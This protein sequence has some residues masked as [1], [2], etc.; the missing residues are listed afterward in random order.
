M[1]S[2][3]KKRKAKGSLDLGDRLFKK[4]RALD[5]LNQEIALQFCP[6]LALFGSDMTLGDDFMDEVMDSTPLPI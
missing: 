2:S 3:Y 4:R 5:S 1:A 6:D